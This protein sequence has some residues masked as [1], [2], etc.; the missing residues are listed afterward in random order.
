MLIANLRFLVAEDHEFQ[1]S[2]LVRMLETLGAK[3]VHEAED[4]RAAL[5][6]IQDPTRPVDIVIS[7]LEMPGMDGMEF[8]RHLGATGVRVSII[9]ASALERKLLASIATMSEAYGINLL[10]VV[11]KP[12]TPGKLEA[13]IKLH[14]AAQAQLGRSTTAGPTFTL[15]EI[16]AGFNKKRI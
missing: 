11:E 5:A 16:T 9:L 10:G 3:T 8:V 14:K 2:I 15:E 6:I 13:L 12:I 4:G 1:R 7:D